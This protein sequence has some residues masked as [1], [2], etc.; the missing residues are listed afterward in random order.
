VLVG[1]VAELDLL[2]DAWTRTS[3]GQPG[4]VVIS[5]EAG[6][7]KTRLVAEFTTEVRGQHA[8]V[9]GGGCLDV[10]EGVLAFAPIVEALRGLVRLLDGAELEE[11]LGAARADLARLIPELDDTAVAA[12]PV[13]PGRLFELLLGV[14]HRVAQRRALLLVIEDLHWADR[15]TR[16]LLDFL[17]RNLPSR[18][19]PV[20]TYRSDELHRC[21]PLRRFLAELERTGRVQRL[22]LGRLDPAELT[23]LMTNVLGEAP[24]PGLVVGILHRSEGNPFYAEELMAAH[25][26]GEQLPSTL[27]D[28]VMTRVEVLS[29]PAQQVLATAAICGRR[30]GHDL[31]AQ[32]AGLPPD[33]L[34]ALL[35]EAVNHQILVVEKNDTGTDTYAFR[36][37]LV[38]EAVYDDLLAVQRTRLHAACAQAMSRG[39]EARAEAVGPDQVS[40]RDLG[41]LAYQWSAAHEQESAFL[42]YIRAAE[43]AE[44][45][46]ALAEAERF[47]ERAVELW[48][49]VPKAEVPRPV[50]RATL[51]QR[52]AEAAYL[53][54]DTGKAI[55]L[56]DQAVAAIEPADPLRIGMVLERK[57]RYQWAAD[58]TP[59]AM[60]TVQEAITLIPEQPPSPQRARVLAAHAQ[61]LTL[62]GR[63]RESRQR[64]EHAIAVARQAGARAAEGHALNTLGVDEALLGR[65]EVG[66]AHLKQALEIALEVGDPDDAYRGYYN[67]GLALDE[68][69]RM[70]DRRE[71]ELAGY[72]WA[73][74]YGMLRGN[75]ASSLTAIAGLHVMLG[76]WGAVERTFAELFELDPAPKMKA[77]ALRMRARWMIWRGELAAA[78]S[79]LI[80]ANDA[81]TQTDPQYALALRALL[82][83]MRIWAGHPEQ[84]LEPVTE[85]LRLIDAHKVNQ[86]SII[87]QVCRQGLEA[88]A[89]L[90]E[91]ARARH[92]AV[93]VA[94]ALHNATSL[95][96]RVRATVTAPGVAPTPRNLPI[97]AT[98]EAHYTRVRSGGDPTGWA[99]AV[100][101]WDKLG[102]RF[103]AAQARWHHAEAL[104]AQGQRDS[105]AAV[106]L[107]AWQGGTQL[108]ARLLVAQLEALAR[109]ARIELPST[110]RGPST[111]PA[112]PADPAARFGLT[113]R[114]RDVLL[115][116]AD[117]RTNRQIARQLY[118]SDK[119]ASVHVSRIL[120][121]L[122][123]TNRAEA[124]AVAHRL[125]I[126]TGE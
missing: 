44:T 124:T 7:G 81:A 117:G 64:C 85:G 11:V 125:G 18:V 97:V 48:E 114:E 19:L 8:L 67:L 4:A 37:P 50:D 65:P 12:E 72:A 100:E 123:V 9:I 29:E 2:R 116:L 43:A 88:Y 113:P 87:L 63:P 101:A 25:Q 82:A 126:S 27:R 102:F 45:T 83:E 6:V 10:G 26:D 107:S 46:S 15:S 77:A 51:L 35:R 22:E 61:M 42:A 91:Q 71:A 111:S 103:E 118:I 21:H 69:G 57:A 62:L 17:V 108:G 3:D 110:P 20:L 115:L 86:P 122:G 79:D 90:A 119:T 92:D 76:D 1:R 5:G 80:A 104:L 84:A 40:A 55:A 24:P 120:G 34:V 73:R 39:I 32:V 109:R 74:R 68:A 95:I 23:A 31:L 89:V 30:V 78:H 53:V 28:L 105:A 38:Q 56:A 96:E 121:K 66:I 13:S 14:L 99:A 52:A 98:A 106:L 33:R 49:R 59:R 75:G 93:A 41:Q 54:Y 94:T 60:A 36:H 47:F 58:D 70:A 112:A 16:D